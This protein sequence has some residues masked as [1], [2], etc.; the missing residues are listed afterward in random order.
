MQ[1]LYNDTIS[2]TRDQS[3]VSASAASFAAVGVGE[4]FL[5]LNSTAFK[6]TGYHEFVQEIEDV[7]DSTIG[8]SPRCQPL[9]Q[10]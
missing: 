1:V 10:F 6:L 2:V 9:C 7:V 8:M 3:P 5:V 4:D